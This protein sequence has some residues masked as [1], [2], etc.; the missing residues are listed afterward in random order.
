M[1]IAGRLVADDLQKMNVAWKH[2]VRFSYVL[3]VLESHGK[4]RSQ[5]LAEE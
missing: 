1:C 5:R 3:I 4:V 2:F